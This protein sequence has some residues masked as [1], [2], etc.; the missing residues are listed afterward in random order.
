MNDATWVL[1][2]FGDIVVHVFQEA[3]RS[4]YDL[5]RLWGDAPRLHF[6]DRPVEAQGSK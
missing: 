3:T 6:D 2:D 5:D 1:L 4:Y